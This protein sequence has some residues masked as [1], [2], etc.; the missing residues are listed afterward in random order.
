MLILEPRSD[1]VQ[2][3]FSTNNYQGFNMFAFSKKS[4]EIM[5]DIDHELNMI[6]FEAIKIYDFSVVCGH[7]GK[8]AQNRAFYM[9]HS[10]LKFPASKHNSLP[11]MAVDLKPY[12]K[13]DN[14]DY[15]DFYFLAGILK[16]ISFN[17]LENGKIHKRIR[18]GGD[19][20]NNN[21]FK[22]NNFNDL[23]HFEMID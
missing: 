15:R 18:W 6:L 23:F 19:W 10:K 12:R 22:D 17:L 9:G 20:N 2:C 16:A 21:D 7:R 13:L 4:V 5:K 1:L 14:I 8:N 11:S 3:H